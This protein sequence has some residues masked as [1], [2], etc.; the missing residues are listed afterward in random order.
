MT[1][2]EERLTV[3]KVCYKC[4]KEAITSRLQCD[5]GDRL[6]T[7]VYSALTGKR[8][9]PYASEEYKDKV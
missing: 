6:I 1:K 8:I 9:T 4:R 7:V 2:N 3:L 5:C